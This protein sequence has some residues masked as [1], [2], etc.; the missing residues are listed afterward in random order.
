[1]SPL[2]QKVLPRTVETS[3]GGGGGDYGSGSG[4]GRTH[5]RGPAN[6]VQWGDEGGRSQGRDMR[7]QEQ[8]V[9]S[10]TQ[11]PAMMMTHG[12]ADRGRS[13]GGGMA[14]DSRGLT[15]SVGAGGGGARGRDGEPTS[16]EDAEVPG[17]PGWSQGL[18]RLRRKS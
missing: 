11:A 14:A 17:G 2:S 7:G 10:R 6:R 16:Q 8:E 1:M 5:R 18:W 15:N 9:H 4:G 12:G 13:Y 3:K